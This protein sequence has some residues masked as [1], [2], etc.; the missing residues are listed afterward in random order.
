MAMIVL[1]SENKRSHGGRHVLPKC[2]DGGGSQV[3]NLRTMVLVGKSA[4]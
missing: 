3:G 1:F 4:F 2:S